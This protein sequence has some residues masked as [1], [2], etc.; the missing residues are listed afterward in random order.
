MKAILEKWCRGADAMRAESG[1][2]VP[3]K[4]SNW[5]TVNISDS[6]GQWWNPLFSGCLAGWS[7]TE[8]RNGVMFTCTHKTKSAL[9]TKHSVVNMNAVQKGWTKKQQHL[10]QPV[11]IFACDD[12]WEVSTLNMLQVSDQF[13]FKCALFALTGHNHQHKI[14]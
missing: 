4:I 5:P 6:A 13:K 10:Q 12:V 7:C 11:E 14:N 1:T 2:Y 9:Q 3:I 8:L